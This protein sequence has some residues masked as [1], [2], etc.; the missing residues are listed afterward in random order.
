MAYATAEGSLYELVS[1][2]NKDVFFH[3]DLFDSQ[4]AFDNQYNP[5]APSSFEIRRVPPS[6]ACEFGRTVQF[7]FDLVGD[8]MQNPT[9]VINLPTWLPPIYAASNT[10]SVITDPS[11]VSYGYTNGIAYFLFELIQF[12][13]DNILLQEF[14]GDALWATNKP[15]GTYGH[16]FVMNEL[17]GQDNGSPLSIGRRATPGQLR[18]SLPLIGNQYV[19]DPG[20]PQRSV[21]QHSY[22]LRCKLRRLEDLVEA[23]GLPVGVK[24]QPWGRTFQQVTAP[25]GQPISFNTLTRESIQPPD[26]RLETTQIYLPREYQEELQSKPQKLVFSRIWEN[27]FTQNQ[28]DYAGVVAGG[29]SIVTRRLDGRHPSGKVVWFF[30]SIAD[31][32]A[33]RL[34]KI[35]TG[36]AAQQA[37]FNSIS[38]QIAGQAR[39]LPRAPFIWRDLTNFS[40][41]EIDTGEELNTM[42]WTLGWIAPQRFPGTNAQ[43]TGAVNFTTADRPTF[44]ID[45]SKPPADPLTGAPN[46]EL[47]VIVEGWARFDTDGKGRAE[48]F[49]GN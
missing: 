39:E 20:F 3:Q 44:Y 29:T 32:N 28:L 38:F 1:R 21:Q 25:Y 18:L 31:V 47:R 40:K 33:N 14:S 22:R 9:L 48:L 46:T 12:Y 37:Y 8:I 16:S 23:S 5:Q 27:K 13:Q 43:P 41:E 19:A 26:I 2:G 24:P 7:D 4:Y 10:R 11:G 30:R 34:W 17:T 42:N 6:T 36:L 15:T 35:N 49:S 45:L